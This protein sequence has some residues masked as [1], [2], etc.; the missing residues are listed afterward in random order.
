MSRVIG[1]IKRCICFVY[2]KY[3]VA[4][5]SWGFIFLYCCHCHSATD[6]LIVVDDCNSVI[7]N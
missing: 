3:S 6:A 2:I 4:M 7:D 5:V 1:A